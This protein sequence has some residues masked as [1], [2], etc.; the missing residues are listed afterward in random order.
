MPRSDPKVPRLPLVLLRRLIRNGER[1]TLLAELIAEY[2]DDAWPALG[3]FRARWW[4]WRESG[5]LAAAFLWQLLRR[6]RARD[7]SVILDARRYRRRSRAWGATRERSGRLES[8]GQDIR[9]GAR[10]LLRRPAF[11]VAALLTIAV[12]IAANTS[13]F[14]LLHATIL[15]SLPFP[16]AGRLVA[17]YQTM[18]RYG[19]SRM[20]VSPPDLRDWQQENHSFES[21]SPYRTDTVSLLGTGDPERLEAAWFGHD[22]FETLGVRTEL[23]REFVAGEESPDAPGVVVL[24]YGLWQRRF[25][26]QEQ[27]L[28][29]TIDLDGRAC[30]VV[31]IA[32]PGFRFPDQSEL[33]LPL[34]LTSEQDDRDAKMLWA[35]GRL[36]PGID[37]AGAQADLENICRRLATLYPETNEGVH[38]GA[39]SLGSVFFGELRIALLVFYAVVCM[40]LLLACA[41]TANLML[42]LFTT[43]RSELAIRASLGSG[44]GR[45]MRQL[46][47]ESLLLAAVGGTVGLGLGLLGRDLVLGQVPVQIPF[48]LRFDTDLSVLLSSAVIILLTGIIFGTLPAL[49]SASPNLA[50]E[51]SQGNTRSTGGLRQSRLRRALVVFEVTLTVIVLTAAA[52]MLSEYTRFSSAG[53]G[54]EP[55]NVLQMHISLPASRYPDTAAQVGYFE[56]ARDR[57]RALPGVVEATAVMPLPLGGMRWGRYFSVQGAEVDPD[58]PPIHTYYWITQSGY[59]RTI[60]L[61]LL[62]GR[63]F[64]D[65]DGREGALPVVIINRAFADRYWPDQ[66]AVGKWIKWG[67]PDSDRPWME[68]VGVVADINERIPGQENPLGCYVPFGNQEV[69]SMYLEVKTTGDP[70][71]HLETVK[72]AVW[73]ID[74][75]LPIYDVQTVPEFL[76]S[77]YWQLDLGT[78][79][80]LVFSAIALLLA[81]V[82][83]YGVISYTVSQRTREVGIRIALG[84]RAWDIVR[85]I[86]GQVGRQTGLGL[87]IGLV[88]SS[89]IV[90]LIGNLIFRQ[91]G[92]YFPVLVPV[93]LLMGL[94]AGL[95]GWLPARRAART[96]VMEAVRQE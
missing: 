42:A 29:T 52:L 41:N 31:G 57:L 18:E 30:Q 14:T 90:Y 43:R 34:R 61:P 65:G 79:V 3:P 51:L 81:A 93:A 20:G 21:I 71:D 78:W 44:R 8:V 50:A 2:R 9:H 94:V 1:E 40:V 25:G 63:E 7:V 55:E 86:V 17:L 53:P 84:A 62:Q 46:L 12:G 19:L 22:L 45:L 67:Q 32:P 15:R 64:T 82:G 58:T 77:I 87:L 85:M 13:I 89:G 56:A 38:A 47:T 54:F 10:S 91:G 80:L 37:R 74:P 75:D 72:G 95:A 35:V 23:G 59:F 27:V 4:F 88:V 33:F 5:S 66:D 49:G 16:E 73:S 48:Y 96:D 92:R 24:G 60:G 68:I 6:G 28:G 76:H 11:T 39:A 69:D 36:N 83:I 26:G 70:A